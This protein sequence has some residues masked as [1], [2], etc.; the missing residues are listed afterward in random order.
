MKKVNEYFK[1]IGLR[2]VFKSF[3]GK[4]NFKNLMK[5]VLKFS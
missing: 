4:K 1:D 2:N 3:Y 5:M